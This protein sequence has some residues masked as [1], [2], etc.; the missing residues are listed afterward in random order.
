MLIPL[1]EELLDNPK[2][3]TEKEGVVGYV[4]TSIATQKE[5]KL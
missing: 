2:C 3:Y 1:P 4:P 5:K